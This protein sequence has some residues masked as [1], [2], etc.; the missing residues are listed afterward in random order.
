MKTSALNKSQNEAVHY[1]AGPLLVLAGAGSGKTRVITN[2]IAYLINRQGLSPQQITAVTFTNKAAREMKSRVSELMQGQ[3]SRGLKVSTFHTLG[4]NILKQEKTAAGLRKG[5]SI[6]DQ[7]DSS[8]LLKELQRSRQINS[9]VLE[10]MLVHCIANWKQGMISPQQALSQAEDD[11]QVQAALLYADYQKQL[12]ACNAVDFADLIARPVQLLETNAKILHRWQD[13]I[14]YL[15]VDEYQ[16]T[17]SAQYRLVSLICGMRGALTVVGDDDQSIYAWRGARPENLVQLKND[18]PALKVVKLEQNYR[19]SNRI[20]SAANGLIANN[21]HVFEKRL[22]SAHGEGDDLRIEACRD[23]FHE[24]EKVVGDLIASKFRGGKSYGDYAILYRSNHQSRLFEKQLREQQI[25]YQVSGGTSFFSRAEIK[26]ALS[27]LKL[28]ANPQDDAA[29]LRVINVPRR[30][31][32][33][34]TIE[35]LGAYAQQRHSALLPVCDDLGL[36]EFV[37]KSSSLK[38]LRQFAEMISRYARMADSEP[39][40]AVLQE[41]LA[42]ID[43]EGW[44]QDT[45]NNERAAERRQENIQ[46]LIEW[47]AHLQKQDEKLQEASDLVNRMTLLDVLERQ[48]EANDDERVALMTLHAAKGLEFPVV[49]LVGLEEEILP[50]KNSIEDDNIEEERRLMYVGITRAQDSLHM[51]YA[52]RRKKYGEYVSTEPSRFLTEL[53]TAGLQWNRIGDPVC[54]KKQRIKGKAHLAG[55]KQM[56]ASPENS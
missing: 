13:R 49:Y 25:P 41:L 12:L 45:S 35:Q 48:E 50:H 40:A 11:L 20:L 55:L 16:D 39:I 18:F 15:L 42:E 33:P 17:D 19:S 21:P 56:L 53:P 6:L 1:T 52:S 7:V 10:D 34:T 36:A 3:N 23:E 14:R 38:R 27:F 9:E 54:A 31:L 24:V 32:G 8:T 29:L 2:K 26:D 46:E 22:W 47:I 4:L 43:Y 44:L 51:S 5:F 37:S 30:G 28:L